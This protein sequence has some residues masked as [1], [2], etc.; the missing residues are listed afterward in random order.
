MVNTSLAVWTP[1][2]IEIF[3]IIVILGAPIALIIWFIK[4]ITKNKK[5]NIRLRLEV[6]KLA[7][8]LE[9]LRKKASPNTEKERKEE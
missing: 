5:E 4:M 1:G 3:M 9:K 6:G 8:E 2:I 7:D